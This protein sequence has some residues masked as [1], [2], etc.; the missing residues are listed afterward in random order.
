MTGWSF[1]GWYTSPSFS[2]RVHGSNIMTLPNSHTIYAKWAPYF[3]G[4]HGLKAG[5]T[6]N[7]TVI[8]YDDMF[9]ISNAIDFDRIDQYDNTFSYLTSNGLSFK[10]TQT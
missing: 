3:S 4:G 7:G 9:I 10:Q 6:I 5:N 1:G 2:S 8:N